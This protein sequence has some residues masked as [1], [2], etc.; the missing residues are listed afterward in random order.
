MLESK[1]D[2]LVRAEELMYNGKVEEAI[3]VINNFESNLELDPKEQLWALILRGWAYVYKLRFRRAVEV[4]KHAYLMSKELGMAPETID[5]LLLKAFMT[6]LGNPNE[7]FECVLEA[8]NIFA[9]HG[10]KT[11]SKHLKLEHDILYLKSIIY[12]TKGNFDK[13]LELGLE[14]LDLGEKIGNKI[15]VAYNYISLAG[16]YQ[17]R[18]D[19]NKGL[20]N[21]MKGLE[22][23][24]EINFQNGI[25][26][27]FSLLG[28]LHLYKGDL[29]QALKFTNQSLSDKGVTKFTRNVCMILLGGIY[30]DKGELNKSLKYLKQ[31]EPEEY[32]NI[33]LTY[34]LMG[35]LDLASKNLEKALTLGYSN[36]YSF[37][38][39]VLTNLDKGDHKRAQQYLDDLKNLTE[40]SDSKLGKLAY[41]LAKAAMLKMSNRKRTQV[42]AETILKQIVEEEIIEPELYVISLI[43][44]CDLL[45]E[46]LS[47]Y[48]N[49][50]VLA[51]I[52]LLIIQLIKIGEQQ[53]SYLWV[54]EGKLLQGKLALIKMNIEEGKS[55]F[56]QSQQ[57]AEEH[58]LNLLA[59]KI[60]SEHD[61]LLEKIDEWDKLQKENAPM[62]KRIKL[63][64]VDGVL[65]RLQGK[66]AVEPPELV[67]E[68]PILL[69]IMD[70]S[71]VPYFNHSFVSDWDM[72]GIFSS[73]MSAF[74]T[75]SSELFSKSIDRI[76]IGENVILINPVGPFLAC[77]VIKG[78]SYSALQKLT[79]FTEA[80]R[81]NLEIWEALN[82]SVKTSEM[83]ELDKP[84]ILKTVINEIFTR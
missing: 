60:S 29:D 21:V 24:K 7:A 52:D 74:N 11:S 5:A 78:Q 70:N 73:F 63:A 49:P 42:E 10:D 68:E 18:G 82:K 14:S 57:I 16:Y 75:F 65:D 44:L 41:Q 12:N 1:S 77:Y 45:Q 13:A 81:E 59:Q 43:Y 72:E 51:E 4:G 35:D 17:F 76:R 55:L 6:Y 64:S 26:L 46:E 23:F 39:L 19:P 28:S 62:A 8:E 27:S 9:S 2:E 58:G 31:T 36:M 33:G 25:A 37:F 30:R 66:G 69:L 40:Q 67:N 83:L 15:S 34:R 20:E 79:R 47:V 80:I 84:P 71:G 53:N 61:I 54:A 22:L 48:N 32:V 3:E 38:Y 56:T 50:E